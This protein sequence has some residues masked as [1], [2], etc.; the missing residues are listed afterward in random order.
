MT[1]VWTIDLKPEMKKLINLGVQG[2]LTNR[3]GVA[4]QVVNS[5][6]LT[7]ANTSAS[8]P[9]ST[10]NVLSPNKCDC[11][12]HN[13]G[14]MISWPAPSGKACKC[15]RKTSWASGGP[16]A[17][18]DGSVVSCDVSQP[19]CANPDE[20]KKACRLGQGDCGGY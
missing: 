18:C 16:L 15:K 12:Y 10:V 7:M 11:D 3:V 2:I 5:M 8:I 14:C 6:G 1:I 4:K 9:P 20:S 13:N 17:S 19:K